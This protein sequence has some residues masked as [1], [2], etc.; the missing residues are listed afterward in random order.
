MSL[1]L[2]ASKSHTLSAPEADPA[3][4]RSSLWLNLAHS[5]AVV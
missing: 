2:A 1:H 4:T 3:H 5:T